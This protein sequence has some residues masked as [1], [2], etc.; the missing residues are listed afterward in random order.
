MGRL[1]AVP[2]EQGGSVVIEIDDGEEDGIV[3]AAR[4]GE[5]FGTATQSFEA[6]LER[7]R[8]MAEAIVRNLSSLAQPPTGLVVE[9]GVKLSAQAGL[10]VAHTSGESNFKVTLE[11][12]A[13]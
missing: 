5:L 10:V 4:P 9:F 7:L 2:L 8:P 13:S 12:Q 11:W 1:V 6:A 3:R